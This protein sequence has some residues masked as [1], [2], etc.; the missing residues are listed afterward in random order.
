MYRTIV[1]DFVAK[2][3][4]IIREV[5]NESKAETEKN[6]LKMRIK[7]ERGVRGRGK[8]KVWAK[9]KKEEA[10]A[11]EKNEREEGSH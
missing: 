8:D 9:Q 6:A 11:K 7:W 10:R 5:E 3:I 4:R 1:R 2:N